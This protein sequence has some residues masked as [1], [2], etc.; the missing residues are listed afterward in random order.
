MAPNTPAQQTH[1]ELFPGYVSTLAVTDPER[2]VRA[3]GNPYTIVRPGWFD[4]NG[5]NVQGDSAGP[6]RPRMV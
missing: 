3:G 1:D 5:P 6:V 2:L 4:Y